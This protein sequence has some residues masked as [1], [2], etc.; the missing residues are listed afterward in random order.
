MNGNNKYIL[1]CR[2]FYMLWS[3]VASGSWLLRGKSESRA[4]FRISR[5]VE[6]IWTPVRAYASRPTWGTTSLWNCRSHPRERCYLAMRCL[7]LWLIYILFWGSEFISYNGRG[8]GAIVWPWTHHR[9]TNDLFSF[10]CCAAL[11]RTLLLIIL[12]PLLDCGRANHF[13]FFMLCSLG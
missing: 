8:R 13:T 1:W 2:L 5:M 6:S 3:L 10:Q 4:W 11:G 12:L 9:F 7:P